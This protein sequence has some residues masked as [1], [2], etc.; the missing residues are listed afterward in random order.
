MRDGRDQRFATDEHGTTYLT[1]KAGNPVTDASGNRIPGPAPRLTSS[2]GFTHY[3][4]AQ[5]HCGLCGSLTCRGNC[6]R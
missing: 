6:F 3:D 2:S 4:T 5:G 1:D